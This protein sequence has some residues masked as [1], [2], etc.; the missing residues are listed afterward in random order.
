MNGGHQKEEFLENG[1]LIVMKF[2][3]LMKKLWMPFPGICLVGKLSLWI[4]VFYTPA[5]KSKDEIL[6]AKHY[7]VKM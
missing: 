7:L 4:F 5:L 2:A 6:A 3:F 1:D